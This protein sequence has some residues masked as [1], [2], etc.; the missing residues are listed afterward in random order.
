MGRESRMKF[1]FA[2]TTAPPQQTCFAWQ[3]RMR[4]MVESIR[5]QNI[6]EYEIIIVGGPAVTTGRHTFSLHNRD[7]IVHVPFDEETG[8]EGKGKQWCDENQIKQGG[9]ITKKKNLITQHAKYENIVYFHDYHVFMPGW[10]DGYVKFGNDWDV[11]MNVIEDIWGNRFRDWISWDQPGYPKRSLMD[12]DNTEAAKHSYIS[13]SYWV[14]KKNFM[15]ENPLDEN[16][17]YGDA[18]DLEWSLRVRDK[19]NYRMNQHSTVRHIRPKYTG[20]EPRI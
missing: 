9:W 2:T 10:Y 5:K 7:D 6:P 3:D 17:V 14:A 12:Y 11:C 4:C 15:E 13:G 18:E 16:L 1:T 20:D 8:I 19:A